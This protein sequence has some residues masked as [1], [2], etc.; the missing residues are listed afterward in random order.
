VLCR[1]DTLERNDEARGGQIGRFSSRLFFFEACV[2]G[3]TRIP[4]NASGASS[5]NVGYTHIKIFI[6]ISVDNI[7]YNSDNRHQRLLNTYTTWKLQKLL[8]N[9]LKIAGHNLQAYGKK[10]RDSKKRLWLGFSERCLS[11]CMSHKAVTNH[12]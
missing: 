6:N 9:I 4:V 1:A 12:G 7:V 2:A 10:G 8:Y 11:I 3:T 5:S